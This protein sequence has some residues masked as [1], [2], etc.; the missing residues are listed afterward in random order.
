MLVYNIYSDIDDLA[1]VI[2]SVYTLAGQWRTITTNLHLRSGS[3]DVIESDNIHS[4]VRCLQLA[5]ID[6]MKL[7]YNHER[8]G[9]PSWR[10]LAKAIRRLDGRIF[11]KIVLEHPAG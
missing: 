6:W 9:R 4:S 8:N 10:M 7:N 3:M 1:N 11:Q 2:E 5:N